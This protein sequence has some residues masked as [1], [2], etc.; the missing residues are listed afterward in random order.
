MEGCAK[1]CVLHI[2]FTL[3]H[4]LPGKHY[5]PHFRDEKRK[6]PRGGGKAPRD[7]TPGSSLGSAT[8]TSR[9]KAKDNGFYIC[10]TIDSVVSYD[11]FCVQF[12]LILL[13]LKRFPDILLSCRSLDPQWWAETLEGGVEKHTKPGRQ[14]SKKPAGGSREE[15]LSDR[16]QDTPLASF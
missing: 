15:C 6:A 7:M 4:N 3:D 9:F 12:L 13:Y 11:F 16:S 10:A 2:L 1:H 14:Y 8:P 5:C